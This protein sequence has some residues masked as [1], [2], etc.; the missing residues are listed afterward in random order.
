MRKRERKRIRRSYIESR[1]FQAVVRYFR[2]PAEF[3]GPP[4]GLS[5]MTSFERKVYEQTRRLLTVGSAYQEALGWYYGI[6]HHDLLVLVPKK[7]KVSSKTIL[8]KL[9][10]VNFGLSTINLLKQ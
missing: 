8:V 3:P 6:D 2:Q 1:A 5:V 9:K 10:D 7:G 4:K